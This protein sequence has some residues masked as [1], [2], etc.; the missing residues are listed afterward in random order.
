M[1]RRRLFVLL[2]ALHALVLV[3]WVASLEWALARAA[4]V[5]VAVVQRD[6][7]DLLRGDFVWLRFTFSQIS[8]AALGDGARPQTGDRVWVALAP[9]AGLWE[10]GAASLSR[11]DLPLAPGQRVLVGTLESPVWEGRVTGP[12]RTFNVVYGV[13][14]YYVPEGR[15]VPPRGTIEAELALTGDGRA[16]LRRVFVD[17]R[18]YP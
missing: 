2:V 16:F 8:T 12:P 5:R 6:P 18:P 1:T 11:R 3:G 9:R 7:R 17:G 14:R 13:E 4:T 10:L 15:G